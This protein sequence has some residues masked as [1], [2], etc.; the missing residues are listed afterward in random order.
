MSSPYGSFIHGTWNE[1]PFDA[2]LVH[3]EDWPFGSYN[4]HASRITFPAERHA[5][6]VQNP[7]LPRNSQLNRPADRSAIYGVEISD[8]PQ[9]SSSLVIHP[10]DQRMD[11]VGQASLIAPSSGEAFP[12]LT[13]PANLLSVQQN[14]IRYILAIPV[15]FPS[16]PSK[17]SGPQLFEANAQPLLKTQDSRFDGDLYTA[18][19]VRGDG[20]NREG[21]CCYCSE[22]YQL[23]DSAYWVREYWYVV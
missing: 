11:F 7:Y 23:R 14:D 21:W 13:T 15:L 22:W 12:T 6:S 10:T 20:A 16:L 4:S 1:E 9:L 5:G 19:W 8:P 2:L 3:G 18:N 17:R